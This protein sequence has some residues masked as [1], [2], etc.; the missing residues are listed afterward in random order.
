[1]SDDPQK[2]PPNAV[3][4]TNPL[5]AP[6]KSFITQKFA[7]LNFGQFSLVGSSIAGEETVV[8]VP[9]LNV[10]FDFGRAP[11]FS[12]TSDIVCLSHGHMDHIAGI[13]YYFSQR[14]FQDMKPG[15]V[16]LPI[17]IY[18]PVEALLKAWRDVERQNTPAQLVAMQP[19]EE[20][21]VRRDFL[22]RSY[23]THHGGA[24]LGYGLISVREKLRP[25]YT[26]LTGPQLVELKKQGVEIQYR[27][28]VPLVVYL[29]DTAAGPVFGH[30]D[31]QNAQ[32][33]VT[34]CTFYERDHRAKAKAGRHLHVDE[35][36]DI[37]MGL[38]NPHIVIGHVSRRTGVRRAK[39]IL[40]KI[41]GAEAMARVHFL[42]DFDDATDGG[43][44]DSMSPV[45]QQDGP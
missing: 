40:T 23:G 26:H 11:G 6:G 2:L 36:A 28:E 5:P 29:G 8:Q 34:E 35:F 22:I 21:E 43:D 30:P 42:N 7:R 31:V 3:S 1:M 45:H 19:G 44:V 9:E 15:K 20:Y 12:L 18:R 14:Y 39:R 17:E 33:L 41:A 38:K 27:V 13:G 37:L 16:L 10:C 4:A 24:S 25:E 32:V